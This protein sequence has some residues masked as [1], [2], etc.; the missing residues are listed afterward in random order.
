MFIVIDGID[1]SGKA[2]QAALLAERLTAEGHTVQKLNFPQYETSVFGKLLAECLAGKHGDFVHFDPKIASTLYALD[3]YE[4]SEQIQQWL[5]AGMTVI[6]DRFSSSNQI[7]QGGKIVNERKREEFLAWL[8]AVEHQVLKIPRPDL[9]VCLDMPVDMSLKLLSEERARKNS[10]L[11]EGE[12]D[13]VEK[14]RMYL[15]RS[16]ESAKYLARTHKNWHVVECVSDG[17]LRSRED[18][19]QD[20]VTIVSKLSHA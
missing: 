16:L 17:A 3:R 4:A 2:T 18:I 12:M 14:D 7:H 11:T 20:I 8:E 15:E 13:V 9:V 19:H 1:G 6:A 5:D 10:E